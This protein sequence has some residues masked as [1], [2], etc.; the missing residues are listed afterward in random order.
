TAHYP[1][2]PRW[3]ELCNRLGLFVLD[4]ANVESHGLSYHRRNLPGDLEL[5]EP[6]VVDRM[7]RMV[8]RD[9]GNPCVVMWSLGNEAGYG[10]DFMAMR[11]AARA[12][13]PQLRPIQYA[14]MNAAADLDSQTYP[15]T[16]WLEQHVAKKAQRKGEQGELGTVPQHGAYPSDKGFMTNEYAHAQANSLGNLQDYWDV[17]EAHAMLWGG[18]IW[19]WCDLTPYQT[20]ADGQRVFVL[21][22]DFGDMPNDSRFCAK[23]MVSADRIPRP[24]YWE[25]KKVFQ[26]IKVLPEDIVSGRVRIVNKYDFIALDGFDGEWSLT[27]NGAVISGGKLPPLTAKPGG[28][29]AVTLPWKFS[30]KEGAEYFVTLTFKLKQ[31]TPWAKAGEVVAWD[32]LSVPAPESSSAEKIA[33][34]K[35]VLNKSG[36]DWIVSANGTIIKVDGVRGWVQSLAINGRECLR[37]PLTPNFWRVPTDNDLG[38]KVPEKMGAW[39]NAAE[40]AELVSLDGASTDEGAIITAN[41]KLPVKEAALTMR[42]WLR[43]DGTLRVTMT[44]DVGKEAPELPRVGVQFGVSGQWEHVAWYGR[45][46][47][48]N[49]RDRKTGAAVGIYR[50]TVSDWLTPYVRPQDNANRTDIR[51]IQFTG[52]DGDGIFVR[53]GAPLLGV[54]AWPY[55]QEDLA[56]TK[57]NHELPRRDIIT[58]SVD[59]FQIGVGGDT[60]WGMPVHDKYRLK[61]KGKYEF[62]FDLLKAGA[63]K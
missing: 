37:S 51:W 5:W 9:R 15:D 14:D 34:G 7:R 1:D 36:A 43:G 26:Y 16:N 50:G 31:D 49:Y 18:F 4:E 40:Q 48:E 19:E 12:A 21:G 44:L 62:A 54:T 10:N 24:H 63:I 20:T 2:D 60:S 39:K 35:V 53:A 17:F 6:A 22:G 57:H 41:W 28:E 30:P 45:G 59:G 61:A 13:D 11:E 33:P 47:W 56:V 46:P 58:V 8:I 32:Q 27:E 42:Y 23:G 38:W 25:A 55:T 52:A 29:Q 3:Y